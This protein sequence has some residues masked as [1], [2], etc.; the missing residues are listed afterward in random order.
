MNLSPDAQSDR[1][2]NGTGLNKIAGMP[3][4]KNG[5]GA[6]STEISEQKNGLHINTIYDLS[7][8]K[9]QRNFG[10]TQ[11]NPWLFSCN[12]AVSFVS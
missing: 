10:S 9:N 11:T 12:L 3:G 5:A 4:I 2:A 8:E 6:G 7:T 1:P